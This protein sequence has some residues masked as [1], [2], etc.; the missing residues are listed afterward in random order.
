MLGEPGL[1]L[2]RSV[3]VHPVCHLCVL[4]QAVGLS[5]QIWPCPAHGILVGR[6][7]PLCQVR[8]SLQVNVFSAAQLCAVPHLFLSQYLIPISLIQPQHFC[9]ILSPWTLRTFSALTP[10]GLHHLL[11]P[12]APA[13]PPSAAAASASR[14]Q[15]GF[16][17][18]SK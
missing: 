1:W 7:V 16:P 14:T 2:R 9:P 11:G 6:P 5:W 3:P 4:D 17:M 8:A 18:T 10:P 13:S 15:P 12:A